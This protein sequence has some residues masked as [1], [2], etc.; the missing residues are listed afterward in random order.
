MLL[1]EVS[2]SFLPVFRTSQLTQNMFY[3]GRKHKILKEALCCVSYNTRDSIQ[4][5]SVK[6]Y[7]AE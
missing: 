6:N 4:A 3:F 7:V 5:L 1:R 2:Q